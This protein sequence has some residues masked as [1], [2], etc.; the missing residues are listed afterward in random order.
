MSKSPLAANNRIAM[1][2]F[3]IDLKQV[4]FNYHGLVKECQ[5]NVKGAKIKNHDQVCNQ[6]ILKCFAEGKRLSDLLKNYTS[7]LHKRQK[8]MESFY[9][10]K[11]EFDNLIK[12]FGHLSLDSFK[13]KDI[14]LTNMEKLLEKQEKEYH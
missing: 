5:N 2:H 1:L 6:N 4:E 8:E 3:D 14:E 11:R 13:A 7:N 12:R 9:R 10:E